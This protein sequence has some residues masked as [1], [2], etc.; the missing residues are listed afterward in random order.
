M[1][2]QKSGR[3]LVRIFFFVIIIG[4]LVTIAIILFQT[5]RESYLYETIADGDLV[6]DPINNLIYEVTA[7]DSNSYA[8]IAI[9]HDRYYVGGTLHRVLIQADEKV[10]FPGAVFIRMDGKYFLLDQRKQIERKL[11]D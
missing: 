2:N 8:V 5:A 11:T 10:R 4:V 7:V 6:P 9:P 3:A 1:K